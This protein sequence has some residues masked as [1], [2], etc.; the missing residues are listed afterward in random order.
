MLKT[1]SAKNV[2]ELTYFLNSRENETEKSILDTV[3][4]IIYDVKKNSDKAI[5]KYTLMYDKVDIGRFEMSKQEIDEIFQ[6]VEDK[7]IE[8]IKEAAQ[9]IHDFH[10]LQLQQ[11]Y[12]IEKE[13]GVYLGQ[14]VLP[15]QKVGI[16]VPGGRASYPSSVLMNAI[17]AKLAGVKEVIM[18]TPPDKDGQI[19][20]YIV[21]AANI[22]KVDRIFK[23][24][25]AQG[26]AALAYGSE[27]IPKVDKIVG[28][29]NAYVATAK[30]L[31]YGRVDIDMI[32]GPSEILVIADKYANPKYVAA[33][34]ISQ[35]EHDP[36]AS[37]ILISTNINVSD[38]V[39]K[40]LLLQSAK[41]PTEGIITHSLTNF[42]ISILVD[43]IDE[44]ISI[45]NK[46]A[47]EHLELMVKN[48][49]SYLKQVTN[50]GSVFLGY[51]SCESIGDYFGGTNHVL[52][53]N[54]TARFYSAL[55]CDSFIKK[56][57]Y[58][59]YTKEALLHDANKIINIANKER[60]Q[61]HANAV[62]VRV[63][64]E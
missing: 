36:M 37:S 46:I 19:N 16:Y 27:S 26:I 4:S 49:K 35:A 45:S 39:N 5:R 18:I 17:P 60:L 48:S 64:N 14:R 34:L 23:V 32:A 40:Q 31:V 52:P 12:E 28:P 51:Y 61:G 56:S 42:G 33:D 30:K 50:A 62:R 53:T 55:S 10:V 11:G 8:D 20:P 44:A 25:G 57:S 38:E 63:E 6:N 58:I 29:G 59:H 21:A 15:L 41:L 9:N 22:A 1:I 54:G 7:F 13:R 2:D 3:E 47:P 24:G 43:S